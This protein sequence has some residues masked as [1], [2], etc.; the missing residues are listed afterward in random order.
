MLYSTWHTLIDPSHF[1]TVTKARFTFFLF[2]FIAFQVTGLPYKVLRVL[3]WKAIVALN[4]F[5]R[6]RLLPRADVL[7]LVT[8]C[9]VCYEWFVIVNFSGHDRRSR[10]LMRRH[11]RSKVTPF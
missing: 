8:V 2:F 4:V 9:A 6:R 5:Y 10:R 1:P 7:S 3:L 11:L